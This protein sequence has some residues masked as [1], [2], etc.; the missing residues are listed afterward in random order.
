M[1]RRAL[2]PLLGLA[3][4]LAL[5]VARA[6]SPGG[7]PSH[8][9]ASTEASSG[10]GSTSGFDGAALPGSVTAPAF[11]LADQYGHAVSPASFRGQVTILTFLY[12]TCGAACVVIA[13]QI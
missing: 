10:A 2:F 13:Q 4:L 9:T 3:A 6:A 7:P 8:G 12:S 11:T 5:A 1:R